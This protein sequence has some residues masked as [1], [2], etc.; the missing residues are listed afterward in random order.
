MRAM[1]PLDTFAKNSTILYVRIGVLRMFS[2]TGL[3]VGV[4]RTS[5]AEG[6]V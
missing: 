6:H 1:S 2:L 3:L 4:S 5:R